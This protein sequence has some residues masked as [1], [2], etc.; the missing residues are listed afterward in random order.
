MKLF[1]RALAIAIATL[2]ADSASAALLSIAQYPLF[3][4]NRT[5]PNILVIYDNSESMD[6]T[7]AGKLIA[8]DD[9]TTR[10][11][12][13]RGVIRNTISTFSGQF[14]WGLESFATTGTGLYSTYP[15][16][17]GNA[18]TMVFTD[19]CVSG[20]SASNGGLRCIVNP[21]WN[22]SSV[23]DHFITYD[24]A[25]DDPDINDV[26]Y[27]GYFGTGAWATSPGV[28][29]GDY[30]FYFTHNPGVAF[31]ANMTNFWTC[32]GFTPTDAGYIPF[33]PPITR[34]LYAYRAWGFYAGVN[35]Q[36]VINEPVKAPSVAGHLSNIQ[37][38]LASETP[39][40]PEIKNAAVFTPLAGSLLTARQYFTGGTSPISLSCQKSFIMLATDGNPT[41]D[42]FRHH[43]SAVAT[44]EY[45]QR[46][47]RTWTFSRAA[48]DVFGQVSAL[49]NVTVGGFAHDIQTY[50]V[51]MGDTVAN[52]SSVA[53]MNQFASLGG[54]NV[55]YLA[56]DSAS[57]A[58][59]FQAIAVDIESK[60][61]S[62][63]GGLA[64]HRLVGH[65]HQSLPGALQQRRL[66]RAID[67][68]PDQ[69]RRLDRRAAVGLRTGHQRPEL[70]YRTDD[71]DLQ[72]VGSARRPRHSLPL[73]RE[74]SCH[75]GGDGDGPGTS[76]AP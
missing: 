39:Y 12:I 9:P 71:L 11:N 52:P 35:G 63:L 37:A 20:V 4:T 24:R 41:S 50:V 19:D 5:L 14:N 26:L 65:G 74:L 72:A 55:A 21:Q 36:G 47:T 66:V 38:M 62:S 13:A 28:N 68:L 45:L 31:E 76:G 22:G 64:Q 18:Q 33:N 57:L 73:A 67:R 2:L 40:G 48:N 16:W 3:L 49:R 69:C 7:M 27:I 34:Q 51:G 59:A 44:T 58:S 23:G 1:K 75:P 70:G 54:T 17:L 42:F 60:T 53:A 29:R 32:F 8:G 61:A 25:S 56:Q 43:V 6:G 10:G 46:G 15:Y 30:C